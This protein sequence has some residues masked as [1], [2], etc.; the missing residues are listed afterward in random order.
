V[1][2]TVFY[3]GVVTRAHVTITKKRPG[4]PLVETLMLVTVC[5]DIHNQTVGS[6]AK[7]AFVATHHPSGMDI[8]EL[9]SIS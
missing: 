8:T 9:S 4:P 2:P 7:G 5:S 3:L 1:Y 6:Q